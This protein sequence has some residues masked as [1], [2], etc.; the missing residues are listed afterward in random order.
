MVLEMFG[1]SKCDISWGLW[2]FHFNEDDAHKSQ[3]VALKSQQHNSEAM[4]L[5][6]RKLNDRS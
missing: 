5:L 6:R 1:Q 2:S 3:D 4:K